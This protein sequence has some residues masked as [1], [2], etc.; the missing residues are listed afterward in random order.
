M[1][2]DAGDDRDSAEAG[3]EIS[4]LS[5]NKDGK[6]DGGA[7]IQNCG[8]QIRVSRGLQIWHDVSVISDEQ[9][10]D[11]GHA[12]RENRLE[13]DFILLSVGE[14]LHSNWRQNCWKVPRERKRS[15]GGQE[16]QATQR[17]DEH[18]HVEYITADFEPIR[19]NL[20]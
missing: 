11:V 16:K 9:R 15:D 1:R 7:S 19:L 3:H 17:N 5:R 18:F 2:G 14:F 13:S 8:Q 20:K 6:D 4:G 12:E 10:H